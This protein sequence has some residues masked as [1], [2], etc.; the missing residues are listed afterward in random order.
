MDNIQKIISRALFLICIILMV[1]MTAST[2]IQVIGR[3]VFGKGFSWTDELS[4]YCMLFVTVLGG[5]LVTEEKSH[6]SINFLDTILPGAAVF[7]LDIIRLV[8]SGALG[9]IVLRYSYVA[10]AAASGSFSTALRL[11]M[12]IVYSIFPLGFGLMLIY[13]IFGIV[14][15]VRNGPGDHIKKKNS[16]GDEQ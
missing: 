3:Y 14:R 1:T 6:I 2:S 4:R 15:L 5:V 7:V 13:Q 12:P 11:P 10:I 9:V 16:G 8:I